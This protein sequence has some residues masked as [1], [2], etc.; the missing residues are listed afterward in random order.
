MLFALESKPSF[1]KHVRRDTEKIEFQI[2][3]CSL[4]LLDVILHYPHPD[5]HRERLDILLFFIGT[6][7]NV[8]IQNELLGEWASLKRDTRKLFTSRRPMRK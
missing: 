4:A 1:L 7:S 2:G 3:I 8:N 5:F 6:Y